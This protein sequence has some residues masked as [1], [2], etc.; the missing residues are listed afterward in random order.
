MILLVRA[1]AAELQ[2]PVTWARTRVR[3]V[4]SDVAGW[5]L[6]DVGEPNQ[7]ALERVAEE[8]S[9][10]G[11]A[12][13]LVLGDLRTGRSRA[14]CARPRGPDRAYRALMA[15]LGA[16][17]PSQLARHRRGPLDFER[18]TEVRRRSILEAA[19]EETWGH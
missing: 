8:A 2:R 7:S 11:P 17:A 13:L 3:L 12:L 5:A 15:A 10:L 19:V 16:P 18:T 14:P 9:A 6:A 1:T 4:D